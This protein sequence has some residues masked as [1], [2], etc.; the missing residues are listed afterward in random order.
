MFEIRRCNLH[1]LLEIPVRKSEI[2]TTGTISDKC[3][4]M[5]AYAD[6]L[7]IMGSKVQ[8]VEEVLLAITKS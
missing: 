8:A 5:H 3:T 1:V 4:E 6:Y 7:I 2:T